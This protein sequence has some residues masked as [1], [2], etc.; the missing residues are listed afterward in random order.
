MRLRGAVMQNSIFNI[1]GNAVPVIRFR[2][3]ICRVKRLFY[4]IGNGNAHTALFQGFYIVM[5]VT[6]IHCLL[7]LHTH[8]LK[9][10]FDP[11]PFGSRIAHNLN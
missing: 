5:I 1:S 8:S 2:D 9:H 6:K 4:S 7:W 11:I 3:K 10:G